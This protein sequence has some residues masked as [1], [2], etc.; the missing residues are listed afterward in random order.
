MSA[1]AKGT[2]VDPAQS[3][4]E[5]PKSG[6]EHDLL[7]IYTNIARARIQARSAGAM[8][9]FDRLWADERRLARS[10]LRPKRDPQVILKMALEQVKFPENCDE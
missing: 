9:M 8:E 3:I 5:V 1:Y 10:E 7:D 2:T 6:Y 4:S